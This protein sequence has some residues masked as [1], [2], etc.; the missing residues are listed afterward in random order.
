MDHKPDFDLSVGYRQRSFANDPV[1]GSDFISITVAATLP[2]YTGRK[3]DQRALEMRARRGAVEA[4]WEVGRQQIF[5]EIQKLTVD[6][7]AYQEQSA[8]FETAII[9]QAE[10]SLKAAMAGYQVDKVDF[11][12]LLNNQVSL[13]N[14]E[15]GYFEHRM[16]YEKSLAQVEA[17]VGARLFE[18]N[19]SQ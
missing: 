6:I 5:L 2:A 15:I 1:A 19:G 17:V 13:L 4:E 14:I 7:A 3:Q 10:Q 9:P 18:P 8:L 16:A 12:T 11:L